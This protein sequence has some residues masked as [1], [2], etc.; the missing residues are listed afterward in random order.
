ME[1]SD[2]S[3]NDGTG[4]IHLSKQYTVDTLRSEKSGQK[5][6]KN[7]QKFTAHIRLGVIWAIYMFWYQLKYLWNSECQKLSSTI[8]WHQISG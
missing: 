5:P 3:I 4:V 8:D 1:V 7:R 6:M 2:D